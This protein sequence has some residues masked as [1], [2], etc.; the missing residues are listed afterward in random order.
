[1]SKVDA[2]ELFSAS[3]VVR[4]SG[5]SDLVENDNDGKNDFVDEDASV[6]STPTIKD[7][8]SKGYDNNLI[9]RPNRDHSTSQPN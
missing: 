9:H 5:T 7:G 8:S 4:R 6:F 1:M 2:G 3:L